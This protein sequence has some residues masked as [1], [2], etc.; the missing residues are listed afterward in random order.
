MPNKT[1]I[2]LLKIVAD[3]TRQEILNIL[4]NSP[5]QNPADLAKKLKITRPG[6]EKHLKVLRDYLIIER[7]VESWP[8]PRYVYS[9]TQNGSG[10]FNRLIEL[11]EGFIKEAQVTIKSELE[12]IEDRFVLG[13]INRD[14]YKQEIKEL[15]RIK[16]L[17]SK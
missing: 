6:I 13:R 10:F 7:E 11:I 15:T 3:P 1:Q 2:E 16:N 17:L 5:P 4:L 12:T 14:Q 9:I 8:T